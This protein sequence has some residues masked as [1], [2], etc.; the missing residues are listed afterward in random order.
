MDDKNLVG[1]GDNSYTI[2]VETKLES[3]VELLQLFDEKMPNITDTDI[4]NIDK[5]VQFICKRESVIIGGALV[6]Y[7][8]NQ[9]LI[10]AIA[11]RHQKCGIGEAMIK[12]ICKYYA[13]LNIDKIFVHADTRSKGFYQK[14]GF[15]DVCHGLFELPKD[16]IYMSIQTKLPQDFVHQEYV[17]RKHPKR[18]RPSMLKRMKQKRIS[19]EKRI[20]IVP[21]PLTKNGIRRKRKQIQ[22]SI[23]D[24]KII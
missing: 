8:S 23:N 1:D 22:R 18:S 20:A 3:K 11:S 15:K 16:T 13:E 4:F 7:D 24:K 12:F 2:I 21:I 10:S 6:I 14:Q 19:K 5:S 17:K 9:Y